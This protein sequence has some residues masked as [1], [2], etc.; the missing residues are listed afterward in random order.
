LPGPLLSRARHCASRRLAYL[1][2]CVDREIDSIVIWAPTR[3]KGVCPPH[4]SNGAPCAL[5]AYIS[6]FG[7]PLSL[8]PRLSLS[9][10]YL[11]IQSPNLAP[12]PNLI[13]SPLYIMKAWASYLDDHEL[14]PPSPTSSSVLPQDP[15][16]SSTQSTAFS[17]A[18]TTVVSCMKLVFIH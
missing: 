2:S 9:L 8:K 11:D 7:P 17:S 5:C 1:R 10:I 3:A 18:W 16:P 13:S 6:C 14:Y 12:S 4:V 15:S